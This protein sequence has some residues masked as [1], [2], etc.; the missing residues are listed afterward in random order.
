[1]RKSSPSET[2][3]SAVKKLPT[4]YGNCQQVTVLSRDRQWSLSWATYIHSSLYHTISYIFTQIALFFHLHLGLPSDHLPSV[5]PTNN[6]YPYLFLPIHAT[7]PSHLILLNFITLIM[8]VYSLYMDSA[9]IWPELTVKI[10]SCTQVAR[11]CKQRYIT[12][13]Y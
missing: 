1:M 12:L 4:I 5:F 6:L 9:Y 3:R 2:E 8:Y 13:G 7:C 10:T 11:N